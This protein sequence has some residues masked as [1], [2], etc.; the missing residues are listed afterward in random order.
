MAWDPEVVMPMHCTGRKAQAALEKALGQAFVVASVGAKL[1]L[2]K[3]ER[4]LT[5]AARL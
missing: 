4:G 3:N 1:S 5:A 2:G